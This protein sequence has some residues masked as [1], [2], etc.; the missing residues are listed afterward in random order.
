MGSVAGS[1]RMTPDR[2]RTI[3]VTILAM[4]LLLSAHRPTAATARVTFT[5]YQPVTLS[6]KR[7]GRDE[8]ITG[9]I[10]KQC[11]EARFEGTLRGNSSTLELEPI[12]GRPVF[13]GCSK[14]A[15]GSGRAKSGGR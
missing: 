8:F 13:S 9:G 7:A 5:T 11:P 14:K 15:L 1:R 4:A 3:A 6:G 12:Y 2:R 10:V